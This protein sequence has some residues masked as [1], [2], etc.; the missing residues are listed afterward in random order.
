MQY[1]MIKDA[2]EEQIESGMLKSGHKLPSERVL[3]E[4]FSTTRITL[5]EALNHLALSGKVYKEERRGWF[6][7]TDT[8]SFNPVTD[9]DFA[10]VCQKQKWHY[11][12]SSISAQRV[13]APKEIAE[14]LQL[15]PFSY[16]IMQTKLW[17]I[18]GRKAAVQYQ[19]APEKQFSSIAMIDEDANLTEYLKVHYL[20]ESQKNRVKVEVAPA[21]ELE[22]S[23]L[24][25]SS[26]S[27]L[28]SIT[29]TAINNQNISYLLQVLRISH[30]LVTIEIE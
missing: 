22:S 11:A 25:I 13:L 14:T 26:G 12:V 3:A 8:L 4:S 19:Y 7:S 18:E 20:C 21:T 2:I 6:V 27:M 17:T 1:L 24:N 9:T 5:R 30:D 10:K 15:P 23:T 29:Q 16:V 28:M